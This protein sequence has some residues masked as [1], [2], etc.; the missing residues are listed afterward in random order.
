VN[1]GWTW[2]NGWG[3]RRG[4]L[5][6]YAIGRTGPPTVQIDD[7]LGPGASASYPVN[8]PLAR[9]SALALWSDRRVTV[10]RTTAAVA[11]VQTLS[12]TGGTPTSG[13]FRL[14][15]GAPTSGF[16]QWNA[17]AATVQGIIEA[18]SSIGVGNV[19]ATGGPLP[20]TPITL[21]YAAS[22]GNVENPIEASSTLSIG[23]AVVTVNTPGAAGSTAD[24][25]TLG[26]AVPRVWGGNSSEPCPYTG[27]V[28][29]ITVTNPDPAVNARIRLAFDL[30]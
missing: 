29:Q 5:R 14:L 22:L 30:E 23:S 15:Y 6:G 2:R 4:A 24:T 18:V 9:L 27:D 25:I 7:V 8:L 21:T 19:V 11:E 20:G 10:S 1:F 12:I 17:S 16:I 28:G 3:A 13:S 26:N